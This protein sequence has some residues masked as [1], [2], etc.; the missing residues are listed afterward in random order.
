MTH[1]RVE[2]TACYATVI[3]W[4]W[5]SDPSSPRNQRSLR[6]KLLSLGWCGRHRRQ[7]LR[8]RGL[9][10]RRGEWQ[11]D[12]KS[13]AALRRVGYRPASAELRDELPHD[14]QSESRACWCTAR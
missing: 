14:T 13:G 7:T 11:L 2:G 3:L 6:K 8:D 4:A 12:M 1:T 10:Y 9:Q 5:C